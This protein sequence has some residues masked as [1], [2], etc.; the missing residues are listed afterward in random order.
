LIIGTMFG[1]ALGVLGSIVTINSNLAQMADQEARVQHVQDLLNRFTVGL[2]IALTLSIVA[3]LVF[4]LSGMATT[5]LIWIIGHA[6]VASLVCSL[7]ALGLS[8]RL[9]NMKAQ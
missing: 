3:N 4:P 2:V 7:V 8:D 1:L 9:R 6:V 5:V